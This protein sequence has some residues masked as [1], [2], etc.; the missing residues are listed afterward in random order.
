M[1]ASE[2]TSNQVPGFSRPAAP[3]LLTET[4]IDEVSGGSAPTVIYHL[5]VLGPIAIEAP[6]VGYQDGSGIAVFQVLLAH[7]FQAR[8]PHSGG[9]RH[10]RSRLTPDRPLGGPSMSPRGS[11]RSPALQDP[12]RVTIGLTTS[13]APITA[14]VAVRALAERAGYEPH[15]PGNSFR[16]SDGSSEPTASLHLTGRRICQ[17]LARGD[18]LWIRIW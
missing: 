6:G 5:E 8:R 12:E 10:M 18:R 15:A 16:D 17:Y 4:E 13:F 2:S 1:N 3:R 14:F 7:R 11:N 9:H